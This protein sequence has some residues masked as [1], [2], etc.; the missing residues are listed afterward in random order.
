MAELDNREEFESQLGDCLKKAFAGRDGDLVDQLGDP[1]DPL[2]V[3]PSFWNEVGIELEKCTEE[4]LLAMFAASAAQHLINNILITISRKQAERRVEQMA[5]VWAERHQPARRFPDRS[6]ESEIRIVR[7]SSWWSRG[8]AQR[9]DSLGY[10]RRTG[11]PTTTVF[12]NFC[13]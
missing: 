12:H 13:D 11:R 10:L 7:G 6:R 5:T 8:Q 1:P 4:I 3:D 9:G 2:N